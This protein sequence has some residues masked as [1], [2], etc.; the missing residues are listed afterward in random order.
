[1]A[2]KGEYI[3]VGENIH[4]TRIRLSSGKFVAKTKEGRSALPY[5]EGNETILMATGDAVWILNA[6]DCYCEGIL[7]KGRCGLSGPCRMGRL[8]RRLHLCGW[9]RA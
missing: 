4:C 6:D 3:I 7:A 1:M 8:V 9:R 2:S 5:K